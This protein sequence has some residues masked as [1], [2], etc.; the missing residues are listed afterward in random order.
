MQEFASANGAPASVSAKFCR[1][2]MMTL[3]AWLEADSSVSRSQVCSATVAGSSLPPASMR[4]TPSVMPG[5]GWR[6]PVPPLP[7]ATAGAT[8]GPPVVSSPQFS[9]RLSPSCGG[10]T[11][12]TSVSTKVLA[13]FCGSTQPGA[14]ARTM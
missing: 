4:V 12:S 5:S 11:G 13:G 9:T 3:S 8:G 14:S 2:A 10:G 1:V 7:G 6:V